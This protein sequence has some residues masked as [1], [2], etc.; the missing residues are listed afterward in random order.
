MFCVKILQPEAED[1]RYPACFFYSGTY[2]T[3]GYS[4]MF[5]HRRVAFSIFPGILGPFGGCERMN[6]YRL[7]RNR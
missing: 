1:I 4:M 2:V 3:V 7:E 5:V 6:K